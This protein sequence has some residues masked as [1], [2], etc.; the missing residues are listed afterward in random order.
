MLAFLLPPARE[1]HNKHLMQ[2]LPPNGRS[3]RTI[4]CAMPLSD[5]ITS[6]GRRLRALRH[7]GWLVGLAPPQYIFSH[8]CPLSYGPDGRWF[9]SASGSSTLGTIKSYGAASSETDGLREAIRLRIRWK[10]S[11]IA[12]GSPAVLLM[13]ACREE[14]NRNM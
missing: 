12:A 10:K 9:N 7:G 3:S 11:L 1:R 4:T 14:A 2:V 5:W 8:F 13:C 6:P